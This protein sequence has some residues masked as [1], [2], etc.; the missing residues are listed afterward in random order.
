MRNTHDYFGW[1]W[2]RWYYPILLSFVIFLQTA[3]TCSWIATVESAV[4][5]WNILLKYILLFKKWKIWKC[6]ENDWFWMT[7]ET[8]WSSLILFCNILVLLSWRGLL[9]CMFK[10]ISELPM[11]LSWVWLYCENLFHCTHIV[12]RLTSTPVL[13]QHE[14]KYSPK[15]AQVL[16]KISTGIS[17]TLAQILYRHYTATVWNQGVW[18]E[19]LKD[20]TFVCDCLT[21]GYIFFVMVHDCL[22]IS[23]LFLFFFIN[24]FRHCTVQ[25]LM[26]L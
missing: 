10:H 23:Y 20:Y 1:Q 3:E 16:T 9:A 6:A 12:Y 26:L 4:N 15:L 24:I 18:Y 19:M 2:I 13:H 11:T 22:N 25:C 8:C 5:K 21:D 7:F 17:L 14:Q